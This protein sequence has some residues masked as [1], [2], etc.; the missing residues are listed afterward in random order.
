MQWRD[1]ESTQLG[2]QCSMQYVPLLAASLATFRKG[3]KGQGSRDYMDYEATNPYS[4]G[5]GNG[6]TQLSNQCSMRPC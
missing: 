3:N 4:N 5:I 2:N 6:A 1:M